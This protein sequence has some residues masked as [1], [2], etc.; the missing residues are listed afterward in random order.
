MHRA[1]T[2]VTYVAYVAYV[3][4]AGVLMFICQVQQI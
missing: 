4:T 2:Y 3:H 1:D